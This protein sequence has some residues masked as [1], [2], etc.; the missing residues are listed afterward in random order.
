MTGGVIV[1]TPHRVKQ[2][3]GSASSR[4]SFPYFFDPNWDSKMKSIVSHL[5]PADV[6]VALK[7][8]ERVK[9]RWDSQDPALFQGTYGN[10]LLSK[11]AKV[12]PE[13]ASKVELEV[14]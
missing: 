13:L 12:F 7:N 2:R 1:A 3:S 4:L 8:R 5:R 6:E 10:Y 9:Q 14:V 11:V